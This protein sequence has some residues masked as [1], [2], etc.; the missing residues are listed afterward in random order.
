VR[1][2]YSLLIL[3]LLEVRPTRRNRIDPA[4]TGPTL[5][6]RNKPYMPLPATILS[7]IHLALSTPTAHACARIGTP[8]VACRRPLTLTRPLQAFLWSIPLLDEPASVH[9][10]YARETVRAR[11]SQTF[12]C[13][14]F[15][16]G[17]QWLIGV[18]WGA[19]AEQLPPHRRT[20]P[21]SRGS[22]A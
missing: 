9:E 3:S 14:H 21:L 6:A 20:L 13:S 16:E 4:T 7:L 19:T 17:N 5:M 1:I 8:R 10:Y 12:A 22:W 18:S 2:F 15:M 11:P